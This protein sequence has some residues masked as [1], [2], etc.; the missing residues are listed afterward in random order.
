MYHLR[1]MAMIILFRTIYGHERRTSTQIII[2]NDVGENGGTSLHAEKESLS[3]QQHPSH[4]LLVH[5]ARRFWAA[6]R[7][8]LQ[9]VISDVNDNA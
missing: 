7:D 9:V 5:P 3:S 8:N 4:L 2:E 1:N 6:I